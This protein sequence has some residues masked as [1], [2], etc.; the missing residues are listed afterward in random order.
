MSVD[1]YVFEQWLHK[2]AIP[3]SEL[4][5]ELRKRKRVPCETIQENDEEEQPDARA[6]PREEEEQPAEDTSVDMQTVGPTGDPEENDVNNELPT[7]VEIHPA[8]DR[9]PPQRQLP[10]D[11]CMI[12]R[13]HMRALISPDGRA[14]HVGFQP[15][16]PQHLTHRLVL[17]KTRHIPVLN[18]ARTRGVEKVRALVAS[19]V[20]ADQTGTIP[21]QDDPYQAS[22]STVRRPGDALRAEADAYA[23]QILALHKPWD[24]TGENILHVTVQLPATPRESITS[25]STTADHPADEAVTQIIHMESYSECLLKWFDSKGIY[26][27]PQYTKR[28]L[29]H[30]QD[31]FDLKRIASNMSHARMRQ[32]RKLLGLPATIETNRRMHANDSSDDSGDDEDTLDGDGMRTA[33]KRIPGEPRKFD[34]ATRAMFNGMRLGTNVTYTH[35]HGNHPRDQDKHTYRTDVCTVTLST[36]THVRAIRVIRVRHTK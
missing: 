29:E 36:R 35:M 1:E 6:T 12:S 4:V 5:K 13:E 9:A 20:I 2:E 31:Y 19:A 14:T 8:E 3:K 15:G 33:A 16:H 11:Q 7:S 22:T 32:Q 25:I 17:N 23:L 26:A 21:E 24:G 28:T 18:G 34:Q 10:P 30:H 27:V